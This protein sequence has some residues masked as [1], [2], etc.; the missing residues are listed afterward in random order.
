[1]KIKN[2]YEFPEQYKN[3]AEEYI[4][5]KHS[6]GYKFGYD[7]QKKCDQLL[8]YL[9][10]NSV[11]KD[12]LKLTKEN[13]DGYLNQFTSSRPRTIH[14]N[15]SYVRQYGL[16][17]KRKGYNPYIYPATLIQCPK[18][19]TPY[20]F[21]KREIY[22][23]FECADRIKPNKNKFINTPHI[24]PAILRILYACGPRIGETIHLK[25]EDVDLDEGLLTFYN[26]KNNISRII[27]MSGSLTTYLRKYNSRIDRSGNQFFFPSLKGECYSPITIRNTFKK[28]MLQ[29][30]IPV[31]PTGKYPRIHDLRHTFAVHSLEHSI[32]EGLDPYCSLPAL[33]T[34]MGHKGIESTEYYLRL[35]KHYFINV[36]H[37]T[38]AQADI[39]FPE[40]EL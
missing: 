30:A 28:L 13:V 5:Y 1:M 26:G 14:A 23:I 16:F 11:S 25:I 29:A 2:D 35:T 8:N 7:D 37:Y 6:L 20:I 22:R 34:Y 18:D 36:L 19:F 17:L 40:V 4:S 21:S 33:S 10:N 9:Y 3:V 38:Q 32:D 24:Y 27:P 12:V 31:L 39:I 15:Q